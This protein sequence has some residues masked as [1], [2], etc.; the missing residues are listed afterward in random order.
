MRART[1]PTSSEPLKSMV[2]S[3]SPVSFRYVFSPS[4]GATKYRAF[5]TETD[6]SPRYTA[7]RTMSS[8]A[9]HLSLTDST[10]IPPGLHPW[11]RPCWYAID[12]GTRSSL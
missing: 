12:F 6:F 2:T 9:A 10:A 8:G 1:S 5:G 11:E 7:A 4:L 3:F